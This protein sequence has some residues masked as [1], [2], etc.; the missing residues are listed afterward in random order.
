MRWLAAI[1]DGLSTGLTG[2]AVTPYMQVLAAP[3]AAE[4]QPQPDPIQVRTRVR[5]YCADCDAW[6]TAA[7]PTW[8]CDV[9]QS[10][11]LAFVRRKEKKRA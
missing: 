11:A 5:V 7:Y 2:V 8:R 3:P 6:T 10:S 4:P 9:C 1:L